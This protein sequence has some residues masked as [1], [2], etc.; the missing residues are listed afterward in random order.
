MSDEK[1]RFGSPC[2]KK[3]TVLRPKDLRVSFLSEDGRTP[4]NGRTARTRARSRPQLA[5]V[6]WARRRR[7]PFASG[8][9]NQSASGAP[10]AVAM[11]TIPVFGGKRRPSKERAGFLP[12]FRNPNT[13]TRKPTD[14]Q[15][16]TTGQAGTECRTKQ[17][18]RQPTTPYQRL[19][20]VGS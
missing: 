7:L 16:K 9:Q 18:A 19:T 2:V 3:C 20:L 15:H 4:S 6:G 8:T 10:A 14:N 13:R 17:C 1:A 11:S 5:P 12:V